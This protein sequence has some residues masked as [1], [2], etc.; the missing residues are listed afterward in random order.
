MTTQLF[1]LRRVS[2]DDITYSTPYLSPNEFFL[3]LGHHF[4]S[5]SLLSFGSPPSPPH[6]L[7]P[8][9]Y[10][11]GPSPPSALSAS[12]YDPSWKALVVPCMQLLKLQ[13]QL[14]LKMNVVF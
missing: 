6:P 2:E 9:T 10:L 7:L 12:T 11:H 8:S 1:I 5:L 4:P 14:L 3:L 13:L